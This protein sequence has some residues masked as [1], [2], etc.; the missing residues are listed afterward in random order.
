MTNQHTVSLIR[1]PILTFARQRR[2]LQCCRLV[3][4][5]ALLL[6]ITVALEYRYNHS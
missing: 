6:R 5:A 3:I 2:Y 4:T 1:L